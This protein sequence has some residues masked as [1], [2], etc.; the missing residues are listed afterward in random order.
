MMKTP[1]ATS[2]QATRDFQPPATVT[3]VL[4]IAVLIILTLSSSPNSPFLF[5]SAEVDL[6][7]H[8]SI[9]CDRNYGDND[10]EWYV[11]I[12]C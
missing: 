4:A 9:R 3:T 1:E 7:D 12:Y 10:D 8:A 5:I 2:N 6:A 11:G